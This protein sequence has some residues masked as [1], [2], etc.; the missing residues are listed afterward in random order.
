MA[1][2]FVEHRPCIRV[3]Q[4]DLDW[5]DFR[6]IP[7]ALP[8]LATQEAIAN[9]LDEQ[10]ARI[11]ALIAESLR[12]YRSSLISAAVTGQLDMSTAVSNFQ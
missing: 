4:W 3:N 6:R 10:T 5:E 1:D 12:E 2:W 11:D 9:F 8:P 7:L